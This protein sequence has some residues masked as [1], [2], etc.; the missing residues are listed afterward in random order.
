MTEH[1][2][3]NALEGLVADAEK[4][5][6]NVTDDVIP[7][8]KGMQSAVEELKGSVGSIADDIVTKYKLDKIHTDLDKFEDLNQ[9]LVKTQALLDSHKDRIE[10][11]ETADNRP[12]SGG[13]DERAEEQA[14]KA[15]DEFLR[16]GADQMAPEDVKALRVSNDTAAGYLA[17][18]DNVRE[19]IKNVVEMSPMRAQVRVMNTGSKEVKIPARTGTF[20][21]AWVGE[22]ETRSETTGLTYGQEIIPTHE[23]SARVD[24]SNEML[25]DADYN[26][27]AELN[28]EFGEQFGV[29]EG[30]AIISGSGVKQPEGFL[31]RSGVGSVNSGASGA[32]SADGVID[33]YYELKT[34]YAQRST[35]VLNRTTL[36]E[37][38]QLKDDQNQYLWQPGLAG[39]RPNTIIGASYIEAPDMPSIAAGA[40]AM[41][42]GDWK[43]AYR[44]IDRLATTVLRDPYT[45][46]ASGDVRFIA[47]KRLGGQC[48]L[49]EAVKVMTIDA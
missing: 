3:K 24:I 25:E 11:L 39:N 36:R 38:R 14:S 15:Y 43:R 16:K 35:F 44:L 12:G 31:E 45:L 6:K 19:I 48:V 32:I 40:K 22:T 46:A 47:R 13:S 23:L 20:A 41:A 1:M 29:A 5:L 33:L 26:M 17:S 2:T 7:T 49:S 9:N 34:A 42:I 4:A 21:A 37:V 8:V 27:S 30:A 18:S 10:Q 28:M